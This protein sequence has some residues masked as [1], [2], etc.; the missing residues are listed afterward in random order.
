MEASSGEYQSNS[1]SFRPSSGRRKSQ[2]IQHQATYDALSKDLQL[3]ESRSTEDKKPVAFITGDLLET[4][5]EINQSLSQLE[6]KLGALEG[7]IMALMERLP[8][9]TISTTNVEPFNS[10]V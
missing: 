4:R 9:Q 7:L 3:T 1:A 2:V 10:S 6:Q 8:Q 5:H